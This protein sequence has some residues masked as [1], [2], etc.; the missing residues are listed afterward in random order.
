MNLLF[1]CVGRRK[2]LIDYFKAELASNDLVVG[3]DMTLT[4]PALSSC[5][6]AYRVPSVYSEDYIDSLLQVCDEH[7]IS[8]VISLNDLELP[9]LAKNRARFEALN[10]QLVLG[11]E[12]VVDICADKWQTFEFAQRLGIPTP[13]TFLNVDDCLTSIGNGGVS[14]PLMVKPRWGSASFGLFKVESEQELREA[15]DLLQDKLAHSYLS[16]SS[17]D[18]R[19]IIIQE[20]IDG[21]EFGLD[22]FNDM[23]GSFRGVVA[24]R[25]L[26]MR[27]GETDKAITVSSDSFLPAVALIAEDLKHLGNLDCDFL[28]RDNVY[29]LLEMNS[30]FGG[31]YPFSHLAGAN[32]AKALVSS[33][34][35][36]HEQIHVAYKEG[37]GFA[38]CDTLV[39]FT[40]EIP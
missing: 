18:P 8:A 7:D 21:E 19:A 16:Q 23:R 36:N 38:K 22:V 33:L 28:C 12:R 29:Y 40:V 25:K 32:L 10:V 14:F 30:R 13:S 4:A 15:Y 39:S 6:Y 17:E 1:T 9:I 35:G 11:D 24:K 2:Y 27:A 3:V 20:F 5:D 37:V 34:R 31:G 26:A